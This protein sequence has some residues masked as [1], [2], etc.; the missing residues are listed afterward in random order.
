MYDFAFGWALNATPIYRQF[1]DKRPEQVNGPSN[2]IVLQKYNYFADADVTAAKT[3]LTEELDVDSRKVPTTSTVTLALNEYGD[4][5][6]KTRKLQLFSFAD[7]DMAAVNIL[8]DECAKV[9]DEL[10][11]DTMLTGTQVIRVQARASTGAVTATDKF[12]S[13]TLRKT[14][15]K[16]RRNQA[17]TWDGG[18]YGVGV[19]PDVV[20]DLREETGQG[21]WLQPQEYGVAQDRLW[22]GEVGVYQGCR[23]FENP[24]TRKA[25]DGAAGANV[26]RTHVIARE[27]IAE[28]M[29]VE[30]NVVISPVVDKLSRFRSLGWYLV[31]GW[32]LYRP[33]ALVRI[34]SSSSIALI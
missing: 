15:S 12:D 3:P 2:S 18:L 14:V 17:Q 20:H 26:Y 21:G 9:M 24:R 33:E 8:S 10:I 29:A 19:H 16:L 5:I 30:P 7:V 34:E 27:A 25:A 1:V 31:G 32:A 4:A 23:F 11:Q 13:T 6:T 28:K 22:R